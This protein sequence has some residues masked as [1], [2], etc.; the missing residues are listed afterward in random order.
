[1]LAA[2]LP[3]LAAAGELPAAWRHWSHSLPVMDLPA[4]DLVRVTLPAEVWAAA[5][6]TLTDLRV[7]DE[8][9]AEVPYV[10]HARTSHRATEWHVASLS[11]TGFVRGAYTQVVA[12]LGELR[13]PHDVV[14]VDIAESDFF[15]WVEVAASD[16][17]SV[18][19]IVRERAPAY[20]FVKDGLGGSQRV[21]YPRTE[22]GRLRLRLFGAEPLTVRRVRVAEAVEEPAERRP[23][24]VP[25][26]ADPA[27]PHGER[28]WLADLGHAKLPVAGLRART[29]TGEFHRPVKIA[30]SRDGTEWSA[31]AQGEFY[32]FPARPT[33]GDG[34]APQER[35]DLWFPERTERH[36]RVSVFDRNDP[37][38]ADLTLELLGTP[39]H[40]VFRAR[41]GASYRLLYGNSRAEAA[42]YELAR[43]TA[44]DAWEA[45]SAAALGPAE[46]NAGWVSPEP[47]SERYPVVLWGALGLAVAVLG[48]LALRALR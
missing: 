18:W 25:L 38:L 45:A 27:A 37:P 47:W 30:G 19:R 24:A 8:S 39:R 32:R 31:V 17:G 7:I 6:P 26:V 20:R 29:A 36:W 10:L 9:G 12:D 3:R 13:R 4:A 33:A 48:V 2:L 14:E 11:E 23:L 42:S 16:D 1:V 22:S 35:L 21:D 40:V 28:R 15:V 44:R 43:L 46:R 41:P 34:A 5:R